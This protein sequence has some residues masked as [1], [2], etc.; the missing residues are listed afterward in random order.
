MFLLKDGKMKEIERKDKKNYNE[1]Q[2]LIVGF[3]GHYNHN[4]RHC[5][6]RQREKGNGNKM[7]K[8]KM[9]SKKMKTPPAKIIFFHCLKPY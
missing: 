4:F 2:A 5:Q 3:T 7:K 9:N 1:N 8:C 6:C